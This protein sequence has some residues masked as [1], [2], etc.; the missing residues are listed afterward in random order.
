MGTVVY[1][2]GFNILIRSREKGHKNLP[3]CHVV[4]QGCEARIH[5]ESFEVLTNS[6]FGKGDMRKILEAVKYYQKELLSKW[7]EYHGKK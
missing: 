1:Q 2:D 7:E 3:H 4:G 6:G 5:L